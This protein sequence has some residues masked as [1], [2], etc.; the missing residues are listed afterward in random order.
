[1]G[2]SKIIKIFGMLFFITTYSFALTYQEFQKE[3]KNSFNQY[4]DNH[5]KE[6][7]AYKKA[8]DEAFKEFSKRVR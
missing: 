8:H 1:M 7:K 4:K 5:E 6:F 3:Q 2:S